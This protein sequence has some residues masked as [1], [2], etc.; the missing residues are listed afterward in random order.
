[1]AIRFTPEYNARSNRIVK[2]FNQK[3]NRA[4]RIGKIPRKNLPAN[5]SLRQLKKS[6]TNRKDLERELKN[7]ELFNRKS[8]RQQYSKYAT[9]Y[10]ID[11][12]KA[13]KENAAQYF[14]WRSD[15]LAKKAVSGYPLSASRWKEYQANAAIL[16][17]DLSTAS[18]SELDSMSALVSDYRQSFERR[19]TGYRGFLSQVDILMEETGFDKQQRDLF[20]KKFSKLTEDEFLDL[21][22]S[23]DLIK[24]IY[25]FADSPKLTGG[26]LKLNASKKEIKEK[27]NTLLEE[28]DYLIESVKRKYSL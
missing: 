18:Q 15:L 13:N 20:F 9:G 16:R 7:L 4:N 22:E 26:V 2:N 19:A 8:V 25:D 23:N 11:L 17:K 28:Q 3:V 21:Y 12:I 5:V 1:M 10:D 14:Q 24:R 27:L 6:Y